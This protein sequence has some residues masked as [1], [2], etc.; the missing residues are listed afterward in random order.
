VHGAPRSGC[1]ASK[2]WHDKLIQQA[3]VEHFHRLKLKAAQKGAQIYREGF[4]FRIGSEKI[5]MTFLPLP[6]FLAGIRIQVRQA[7]QGNC[8]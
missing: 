8:I 5:G 4:S 2:E 3:T 7:A 6:V 1:F